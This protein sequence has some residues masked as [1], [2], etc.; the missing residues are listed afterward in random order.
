[1]SNEHWPKVVEYQR[2]PSFV[3]ES[4]RHSFIWNVMIE[5][6][7]KWFIDIIDWNLLLY[8]NNHGYINA[9]NSE[10]EI[11]GYILRWS[12]INVN[13]NWTVKF[14]NFEF[15][16]SWWSNWVYKHLRGVASD[17]IGN[18]SWVKSTEGNSFTI[19]FPNWV[20]FDINMKDFSFDSIDAIRKWITIDKKREYWKYTIEISVWSYFVKLIDKQFIV[21]SY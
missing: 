11:K 9:T 20:T 2:W 3:G 15:K 6:D 21:E 4:A 12:H 10:V 7:N 18:L 17:L 8:G 1:M 19:K 5:G 14:N 13:G 16:R